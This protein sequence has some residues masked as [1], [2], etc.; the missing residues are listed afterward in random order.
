VT[1]ASAQPS[2]PN[3]PPPYSFDLLGR[4]FQARTG[5]VVE[6]RAFDDS[7]AGQGA[8]GLVIAKLDKV[9]EPPPEVLAG[10]AEATREQITRAMFNDLGEAT[11]LAAQKK[12][13]TT[14]DMKQARQ[15]LGVA[16]DVAPGTSAAKP[17]S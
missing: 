3:Q 6:A 4:L 11:T 2:A 9:E 14:I 8:P 13:K 17:K 1:R 10:L 12:I 15:A 7:Q 5:D 16:D